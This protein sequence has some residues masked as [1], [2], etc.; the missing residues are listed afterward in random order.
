MTK[1]SISPYQVLM[2]AP[3]RRSLTLH[4]LAADA[5]GPQ[6]GKCRDC[7]G[8]QRVVTRTGVITCSNSVHAETRPQLPMRPTP[9]ERDGRQDTSQPARPHHRAA[10]LAG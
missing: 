3:K 5:L 8:F 6:F 7:H 2:S 4:A 9:H 1:F 10:L